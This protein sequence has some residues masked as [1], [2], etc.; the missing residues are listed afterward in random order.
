MNLGPVVNTIYGHDGYRLI[1]PDGCHVCTS[2]PTAPGGLWR[3]TFWQAPII[4]IVDFNGD[5]KVDA[6]DMALLVDNWGK[7]TS[8]CDIGPFAWGD[9][10]VDEKDLGVLMESLVTP[11][12]KAY[13]RS[14][15]C[16]P[17]LDIAL[18]RPDL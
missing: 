7:N 11:S 9:G 6:T 3:R 16:D 12:P 13:G 17:E 14:L 10:V 18:V 15:R 4:P 2:G 5:G 1:S 8:V